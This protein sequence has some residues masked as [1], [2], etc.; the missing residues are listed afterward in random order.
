MAQ[1]KN[2]AAAVEVGLDVHPQLFALDRAA[3]VEEQTRLPRMDL[4]VAALTPIGGDGAWVERIL[5]GDGIEVTDD[6]QLDPP[7]R[8]EDKRPDP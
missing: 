2:T 7:S 6:V 4:R 8:L 5:G 1:P 3:H